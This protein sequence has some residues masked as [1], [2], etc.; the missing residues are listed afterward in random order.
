VYRTRHFVIYYADRSDIAGD[1]ELIGADHELRL[2][3]ACATLGL[4]PDQVGT[5]RSYYFA[6]DEQ[7]GR[8]FGARRVEM[9]KPWRHEIYLSHRDFPHPSLRHEIAHVVAAGFGSPG[10]GVSARHGF[11]FNPGLIEGLAVAV[12]WPGSHP[13]MTPHQ[14]MRAMELLGFAPDVR[15]V[16]S[17]RFLALA[18]SRGYTAAGS[19]VRFLLDR[20]GP[21]AL[22]RLYRSGGD[23]EGV[24]GVGLDQLTAEWRT[25]L[26]GVTVPAGDLA[27]ARERF[28]TPG[29]FSRPC[30]HAVAARANRA[31]RLLAGGRRGAAVK[32]LRRICRDAPD[33][34]RHRM[35]LA[36]VLDGGEPGERAE[37]RAIYRGFAAGQAGPVV[38]AESLVRLAR[39]AAADGDRVATRAWVT[40]GQALALDDDRARQFE[41]MAHALDRRGLAGAFE[42][43]YFFADDGDR[44]AWAA[45]AAIADPGH[46]LAWYLFGLQAAEHGDPDTATWAL[47]LSVQLGLPSPRFRRAAARRLPTLAWRAGA[48]AILDRALALLDDTG[49]QVDHLTAEDWRQRRALTP[50]TSR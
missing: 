19:F 27:A 36:D 22:R 47:D 33:E 5:I 24:Y 18:S 26:A 14:Q 30:P 16:L 34:P 35:M 46:G 25:M 31:A 50:L 9:A 28:R 12:D 49:Y 3:Q 48:A 38:A 1:I 7:K 21:A 2:A 17:V 45:A 41:A 39:I 20:H 32:L 15:A 40:A 29:V 11:L 42:R 13:S 44:Q 37:A 4:D 6:D 10:F 43:G 8:L 23:F